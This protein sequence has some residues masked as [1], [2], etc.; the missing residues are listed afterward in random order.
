MKKIYQYDM[1]RALAVLATGLVLGGMFAVTASASIYQMKSNY[2]AG[3][4]APYNAGGGVPAAAYQTGI[5]PTS[6]NFTLTWYGVQGW[7]NIEAQNVTASGPWTP[8]ATVASSDFAGTYTGPKP[9]PT[10]SYLFR[11]ALTNNYYVGQNQCS[12]CHG[13]KFTQWSGTPHAR[14]IQE[15]L[16]PDGSFIP[17]HTVACLPC[18]TVGYNQTSGYVYDPNAGAANY[19]SPVANVGCE[20]CHGPAAWHKNS[21]HDVIRPVVSVDPAICGSCHQGATHPTFTEYTNVNATALS[22]APLGVLVANV[23]HNGGGHNSFGCAFCHNAVNRDAMVGEYYDKLAG[24]P[25]PVTL[26]TGTA[27]PWTATCATCHD[28]HASNYVAQL[29]YPVSST[30]YYCMPTV[31][32]VR[33]VIVTNYNGTTTTNSVNMNTVFDAVFNPKVQVCGQCH[34]GGR[35]MRWDGTSYGLVT[36]LV[37][38]GPVTNT[39]YVDITTNVTVTQVF[40]NTVPPTTNTYNY[41]YV[42]GRYA[43]N[44][45]ILNQTN[46]VVGLGV[47]APLIA[48]TN[49][50]TVYYSTNSSGFSV[51]HY[52]VQYN[53]LIGQADYD[54]ASNGVPIAT[55]PHTRA[56]NQCADCH[57]PK[58]ATGAHSNTTGHSFVVDFGGCLLSCHSSYNPASLAAKVLNQ[59]VTQSNSMARVVSLLAQWG[60]NVAPAILRTNY[61]PLSWEFP[62]IGALSK[63]VGQFKSGPPSA[64]KYALGAFPAGTNDNL[65]LSTVPQD[66]RMARFSLYVIYEDQS[67]G[68]HNPTYVS[69]LLADA[70]ARVMNQFTSSNYPA[71]F[72]AKTLTGFAPLSVAFTNYGTASS[73]SWN[74]G[75]GQNYSGYTAANPTYIYNTPG[76]YSVTCTA[77]GKP[78]TR[79]QYIWVLAKPVVSFTADATDVV[80]GTTVNFSNTSSNTNSVY[81]WTWSPMFG[82]SGAPSYDTAGGPFSFTYT[83]AGT[84]SVTLRASG[85]GGSANRVTVTN[86]AYITVH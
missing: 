84:Y 46:P 33:S 85:P 51:P 7:Y 31:T 26:V 29:R 80:A 45:V 17:G 12:S 48:Y 40:T 54:Y 22:S 61:G 15:H 21:D 20:A 9:D 58:Y 69:A 71:S 25:H 67:L 53:I 68:V 47:Y 3:T 50:G 1:R 30:N 86:T 24:N 70:E 39:V 77:D 65:Q 75:D 76:L 78:L 82:V 38:T 57:V 5:T 32:D 42:I 66:I 44:V 56:P 52:P 79:A 35:G 55:H 16:N 11:L 23:N 83:N 8:I 28:P 49:G 60:T 34:S 18:H 14:A 2:V 6:T 74:F 4:G 19:T 43:T 59:K 62:S 64:Y 27:T 63:A 73:Y 37:S 13:D 81:R 41:T 10:N 36:N 72:A